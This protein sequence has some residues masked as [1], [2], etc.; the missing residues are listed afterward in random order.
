MSAPSRTV[1]PRNLVRIG[2]A[3]ARIVP[4]SSRSSPFTTPSPR[5]NVVDVP[6]TTIEG[7][8]CAI[9]HPGRAKRRLDRSWVLTLASVDMRPL[10]AVLLQD[11]VADAEQLAGPLAKALDGTGPAILPLDA[12]L[13]APR[14]RQL[15]DAIAPGA[16]V[17]EDTAVVIV[18]SGSTGEPKG[19][20]LS[21]AALRHSARASL[22]R[23][24]A[25]DG[26]GWLCCLPVT[27][28]AGLQVL[29]RSLLS[30]SER[31]VAP[32]LTVT[33]LSESACSYLSVVP[34]QL[35]R[36]LDE[37]GGAAALAEFAA[38]LVGGAAAPAGLLD[39]ARA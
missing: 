7:G 4:S 6:S 15:I 12:T 32:T 39:R 38:V 36:L 21:A 25:T 28:V 22:A 24:G 5:A 2:I 18:T 33:A 27:H 35:V 17:A 8:G 19:V 37:P 23:L 29:V 3:N 9:H 1:I 11:A 16:G 10:H 26:G 31:T 20:E 13:P 30:S 34:T 14:L